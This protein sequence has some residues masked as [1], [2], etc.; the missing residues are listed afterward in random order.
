MG[1]AIAIKSEIVQRQ[2]NYVEEINPQ[3]GTG[4]RKLKADIKRL[5]QQITRTS[6]EI[7]RRNKKRKATAKEKELFN[8]LKKLMVGVDPTTRILKEYKES[9][10][11]K[12]RYKKGKLQRFIERGRRIMDNANFERDQKEGQNL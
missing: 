11:D 7:Y 4:E 9:W 2:A 12:L 5:R 6:N 8:E 10:I 3:K 1:K